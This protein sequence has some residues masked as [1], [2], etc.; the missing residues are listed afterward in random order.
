MF[1]IGDIVGGDKI[2]CTS[3]SYKTT[4]QRI[5]RKCNIP[6]NQVGNPNFRCKRISMEKVKK[7]VENNEI[8]RLAKISQF[9]VESA[10]FHLCYGGCHFGCFSA[11]SP[12]E[13]LHSINNGICPDCLTQLFKRELR[14]KGE[15]QAKLDNLCKVMC[16]LD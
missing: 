6:G 4:L 7:L 10:F 9:N 3:P 16:L 11:A 2:C 5:C 14:G 13:S 15:Y 1:I 12:I 8:E